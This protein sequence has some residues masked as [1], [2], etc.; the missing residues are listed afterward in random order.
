MLALLGHCFQRLQILRIGG[1][2]FSLTAMGVEAV[3]AFMGYQF[4]ALVAELAAAL[5]DGLVVEAQ[6][7]VHVLA[8]VVQREGL[9]VFGTQLGLLEEDDDQS[10]E[11]VHLI[12]LR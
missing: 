9:A 6:Q 5:Q 3:I 11:G 12:A 1:Q 10:V 8:P 7:S 2:C 4:G